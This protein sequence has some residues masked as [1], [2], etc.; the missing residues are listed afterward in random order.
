[1]D[2]INTYNT[3]LLSDNML[4][5]RQ[6]EAGF[7]LCTKGNGEILCNDKIFSI[8]RGT[9][10]IISPLIRIFPLFKSNDLEGIYIL[11]KLEVMYPIFKLNINTV[12]SINLLEHPCIQLQDDD[13]NFIIARKRLIDDKESLSKN[14]THDIEKGLTQQMITLLKEETI[15]EVISHYFRNSIVRPHQ[16]NKYNTLIYNFLDSLNKNYMTERTVKHYANA[17]NLSAG[18]FTSIIKQ[19]TGKTPSEW[20]IF[21]TILNAR[22]MLEK[23]DKRI[24]EI[25]LTLNFPEQFT[26][27]KYFKRH[28]GISPRLYRKLHSAKESD[29]KSRE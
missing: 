19:V 9:I 12:I 22:V 6:N 17:A 20:I 8:E 27:R 2:D 16:E 15:L 7:F 13:I 14:S 10:L 28:V 29:S 3:S 25:A 21:V 23:T 1:M 26:F 18:R 5:Q 24:K 11:E 4:S